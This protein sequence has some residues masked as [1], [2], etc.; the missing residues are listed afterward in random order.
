MTRVGQFA[1]RNVLGLPIILLIGFFFVLPLGLVFYMAFKPHDPTTMIGSGYTLANLQRFLTDS[2]Y[3][4]AFARTIGIS[5]AATIASMILGF[6]V[7]W[8]LHQLR[9]GT[10][11][12]WLTLIVLLPLM[13]SL[14]VASFSWI[15]ILGN[16]GVLN[17]GLMRLGLI[18][19]PIS[20]MNTS[21]G[22][23]IVTTFSHISYVILTSFAALENIDPSLARAARIHGAKESVVFRRIILPLSLPGL[24]AGGLIVFSLSMAAFVIP[25]LIGGGR[26][27]VTPLLIYQFTVQFFD[28]PGAAAL[29]LL[30][31]ALTLASSWMIATTAQR[32]MP[33]ERSR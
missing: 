17:S 12:L 2:S 1:Q 33:W 21:L 16:N 22:V 13:V 18:S 4:L 15:L 11:R 27:N 28:W 8:H 23:I 9:S 5:V 32:W 24:I 26:V 31:F 7:A 29:G 6:P 25:F 3:L 20:L 10:A 30:L 14:V 19:E